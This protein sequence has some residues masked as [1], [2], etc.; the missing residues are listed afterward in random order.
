LQLPFFYISKKTGARWD[1]NEFGNEQQLPI[2]ELVTMSNTQRTFFEENW[3]VIDGF[4]DEEYQKFTDYDIYDY[5]QV[6][7]FYDK[8]LCPRNIDDVF[9]MSVPDIET[10]VP[11][12]SRGVKNTIILRAN[13]FIKIGKLDSLKTIKALE[14]ALGCELSRAE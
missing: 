14:K 4:C 1:W 8:T 6:S 10:K 11:N 5:L 3:V 7:R 2:D 13:D 9:S 12:M